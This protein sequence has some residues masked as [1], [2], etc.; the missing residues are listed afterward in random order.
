[1]YSILNNTIQ[2]FPKKIKKIKLFS[3]NT[4]LTD[5]HFKFICIGTYPFYNE[6]KDHSHHASSRCH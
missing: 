2:V 4:F 1:M 5:L 3:T 6:T